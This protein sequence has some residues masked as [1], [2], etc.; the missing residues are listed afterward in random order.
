MR[1]VS[2]LLAVMVVLV[3]PGCGDDGSG[4]GGD[5]SGSGGSGSER[6]GSGG[7]GSGGSASCT[8]EVTGKPF[9]MEGTGTI[10]GIATI[11]DSVPDGM[12]INLMI[13]SGG[14]GLGVLGESIFDTSETCGS[15]VRF[16]I[17]GV[18]PGSYFISI[19]IYDSMNDAETVFESRSDQEITVGEGEVVDVQLV[20]E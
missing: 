8:P 14:M 7:A 6:A 19:E 3:A 16:T 1:A 18:E 13:H 11:P 4:N 12:N 15:E 10:T 20:F 17:D 9:G 2:V 5:G